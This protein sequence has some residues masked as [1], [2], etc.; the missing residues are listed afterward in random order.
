VFAPVG[1]LLAKERYHFTS[2]FFFAF[3]ACE[4]NVGQQTK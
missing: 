3:A 1:K 2:N 4:L